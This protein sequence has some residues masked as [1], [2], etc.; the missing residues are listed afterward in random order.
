MFPLA[1]KKYPNSADE[2]AG[3][4]REALSEVLSLP[5]NGSAVVLEAP[6]YPAVK[7]MR[8]DLDGARVHA[9]TPP[10]PP[11]PTGKR[12]PGISVSQLEVTARPIKYE[13]S[14]V[15]VQLKGTGLEFEFAKDKKG[16]PLLVLTDAEDGQV[17]L[18]INKADVQS[19][20]T[21]AASAAVK[22]QGVTIKDV[23]V[24][25]R[26]EGKRSV[27][28]DVR[29][30]AKK[31]MVRGVIHIKGKL[32]VDD[33][34]NATLSGLECTG[35]GVVGSIVAGIVQPKLKPHN[36]R[37]IPLVAFSLGEVALRELKIDTKNGLHVTARFGKSG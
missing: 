8:V 34:L 28:A 1:G 36:G 17:D 15:D 33:E 18:R 19:L 37:R 27:G 30:N 5:K 3:S 12:Q 14:K 20:A 32:D 29:V 2:L 16:G 9:A 35:E 24:N 23:E 6:K 7:K 21:A 11:K 26:S 25:L 22:E 13:T 10:P 31:L 4:I